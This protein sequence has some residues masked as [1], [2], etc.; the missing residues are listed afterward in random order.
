MPVVSKVKDP[1]QGEKEQVISEPEFIID[2]Y[3]TPI[4]AIGRGAYGVVCSAIDNR[5]GE[6]VAIKKIINAFSWQVDISLLAC[7]HPVPPALLAP[8]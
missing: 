7:G 2:P 5:T 1:I 8:L 4:K 3:Y 6:K